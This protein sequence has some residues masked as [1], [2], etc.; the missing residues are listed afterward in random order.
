MMNILI[1]SLSGGVGAAMFGLI[2]HIKPRHLPF[3]FVGGMLITF[4]M[5]VGMLLSGDNN[6]VSNL[7]AGFVGSLYCF[8]MARYRKAPFTVFMVPLLFPLVPG[9]AL[10][11]S[12]VGFMEH[13]KKMFLDNIA[14]ATEI[15]LGIA[16]GTMIASLTY[17]LVWKEKKRINS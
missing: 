5:L 6:F 2:Y 7:L 10:F 9:R 3:T 1:L 13:N 15:A 4:V 12:M 17:N 14:T 16:I 8:F 11:Y